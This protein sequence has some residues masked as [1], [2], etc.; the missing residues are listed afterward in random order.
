M[1]VVILYNEIESG[2]ADEVDVLNQKELVSK[3]CISLGHEIIPLAIGSDLK[4]NMQAVV[5]EKPDLVFN[6]VESVWGMGELIYFAPAVLNSYKIPY[7]GVP[8][9]AL[10]LTTSKVLAKKIM[11]K[12]GLPTA[13]FFSVNETALLNPGRKYIV[14]PVWEEASVGISEDLIFSP[15]E[16]EKVDKIRGMDRFHYFIEEFIDGREFN[17]SIIAGKNGPEVLPPAEMIFS[18][19]FDDKPR[20][21]GYKAKWDE[22]SDE[23]KHTSRSFRT[24]ISS[25]GLRQ[26]LEDICLRSWNVFNLRGY[27]RID[28]RVDSLENIFILEINGNPCIAPDSGFIAAS[29]EAGY[30]RQQIIDR[31]L[32]DIN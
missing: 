14:K 23:Y 28:F 15:S 7:T 4:K 3:A 31:I 9:D 27:A 6:L 30:S 18:R 10:F 26:K 5:S 16:T 32:R 13:S 25:P 2:T 12:E 29:E 24:L 11:Q 1:R 22:S 19:F 17:I 8:L 20:I 21:V